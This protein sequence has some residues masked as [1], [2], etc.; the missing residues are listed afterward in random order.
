MCLKQDCCHLWV[1]DYIAK[2]MIAL[3]I[4]QVKP[5][6]VVVSL[7]MYIQNSADKV[8]MIRVLITCCCHYISQPLRFISCEFEDIASTFDVLISHTRF[9]EKVLL[10]CNTEKA[11]YNN[12]SKLKIFF[13]QRISFCSLLCLKLDTVMYK[14]KN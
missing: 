8:K 5:N 7:N 1:R 13:L 14:G 4:C 6:V 3:N 11:L 9:I 12:Y 10:R 2:Q